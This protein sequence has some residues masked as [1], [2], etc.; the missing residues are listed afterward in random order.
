MTYFREQRGSLTESL[1]TIL[2]L[3]NRAELIAHLR[4]VLAPLPVIDEEVVVRHYC[5]DER[6]RWDT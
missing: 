1:D 4:R 2:P 6:I 5:F 3:Q